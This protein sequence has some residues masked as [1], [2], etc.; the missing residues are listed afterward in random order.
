MQPFRRNLGRKIIRLQKNQRLPYGSLFCF[1]SFLP[2]INPPLGPAALSHT[3]KTLALQEGFRD[4]GIAAATE[5]SEEA[6]YLEQWLKQ[7]KHGQ[8]HYMERHFDLRIDPRKLVDN[9]RSVICLSYN[10]FPSS[11]PDA[12]DRPKIARYA[13][14]ED[15]HFVIRDKLNS[16]IEKIRERIGAF[17]ARGF[18][19]SAPVL[20]KAWAAKSGIGWIGKNTNLLSKRKGSWFFL[21]EI[22]TDLELLPDIV[23]KDYCGSCNRCVQACPTDALHEPY[24]LDASRC[25]SYATIELKSE[26]LPDFFRNKME[27]W[28]FGCDIC[29]EVCPINGPAHPHQDQRLL[30][31]N[32]LASISWEEWEMM[33]ENTFREKFRKSPLWRTKLSG[34]KRNIHFIKQAASST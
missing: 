21:A 14:G 1:V 30:E 9:A 34:I 25:I 28:I 10:Y 16:L 8:L 27:N 7:G 3:I 29:Q 24:R 23:A 18:T 6:R 33:D 5:L 31:K 26:A 15:Y 22:I 17:H 19:D 12:E 32:R 13:L 2:H 20:E 11:Y 4:V